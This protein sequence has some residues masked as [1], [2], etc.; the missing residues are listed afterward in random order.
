MAPTE[1]ATMIQIEKPAPPA[2]VAKLCGVIAAARA[3]K[4]TDV[5]THAAALERIKRLRAAEK[6]IEDHFARAKKSAS[7]AQ[8]EI[9]AA[10]NAL[11]GPIAE[12]RRIYDN[13]AG[14]YEQEERRKAQEEERRLQEKARLKEE[15]RQIAAA[16][17]AQDRGDT[18]EAESIISEPVSAPVIHVAPQIAKVEGVSS[19]NLWEPEIT[20]VVEC[21]LFMTRRQEWRASLDRLIPVLT[22]ILRPIATAQR[23]S[24]SIPGVRAVSKSSRATR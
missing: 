5:E 16:Q 11:V 6:G 20:D 4:V 17:E 3:F 8:K 23:G 12:A 21:L 9:V 24:M 19:R 10:V 18:Q 14:A 2:I 1:T 13:S 22:T 7:D 15:E